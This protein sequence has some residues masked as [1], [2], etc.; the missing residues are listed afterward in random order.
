MG[1]TNESVLAADAGKKPREEILRADES[2]KSKKKKKEKKPE[3]VRVS[4]SEPI[5]TQNIRQHMS[6]SEIHFHDDDGGMKTAV[7]VAEWYNGIKTIRSMKKWQYVD[8]ANQTM[9]TF[10]PFIRNGVADCTVSVQSI[11]IGDRLAALNEVANA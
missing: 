2:I 11:E 7:P 5:Q 9:A 6:G 8:P 4:I 10:T 1:G 3:K